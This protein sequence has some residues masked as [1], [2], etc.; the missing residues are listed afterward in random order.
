MNRIFRI[1]LLFF[2]LLATASC[3]IETFQPLIELN[4]PLGVET[5]LISNKIY[6]KFWGLN[7][8]SYF[9]GYDIYVAL[10]DTSAQN[11]TGFKYTN[12]EGIQE[13]PTL[14]ENINPV[15][16][17][18]QYTF[19][20]DKYYDLQPLVDNIDYYF[21]VKAYSIEYNIHSGR[22]DYSKVR[23]TN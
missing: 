17:A 15:S 6:I 12:S 13:K 8:E 11:G 3:G 4:P 9:S 2:V 21:Y 19:V 16:V 5:E 10:D 14:W 22:S 18:T 23:Y 1:Y 7:N 20:V